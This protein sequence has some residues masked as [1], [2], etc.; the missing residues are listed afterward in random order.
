ML[1]SLLVSRILEKHQEYCKEHESVHIELPK[2]GTMFKFKNYYKSEKVVVYADFDSYIKPLD[3]CEP[4]P[5]NSYTK[6]YKK[7]E[8][9]S[10]CY[11]IKCFDYNVCKLILVSYT[12]DATQKLV[13]MLQENIRE[14]SNIPMKNMTCGEEENVCYNRASKC[15]I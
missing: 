15:W 13:E 14:I 2:P 4:N 5:E 1:K 12:E 6:Q 10:F 3:T 7:H 8:P 11:Y 9:S